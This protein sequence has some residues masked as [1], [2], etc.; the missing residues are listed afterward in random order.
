MIC[1]HVDNN[2]LLRSLMFVNKRFYDIIGDTYLWKKRIANKLNNCD[3]AFMM[4]N[5]FDG[6]SS[7]TEEFRIK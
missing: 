3:V 5:T 2:T 6:K 7:K 1:E 4:T